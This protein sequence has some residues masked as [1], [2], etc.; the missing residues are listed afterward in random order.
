MHSDVVCTLVDRLSTVPLHL[1]QVVAL[2]HNTSTKY[3]IRE[4]PNCDV[5]EKDD[6]TNLRAWLRGIMLLRRKEMSLNAFFRNC[7]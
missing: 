3:S 4:R 2:G 1:S 6:E 7:I 5:K